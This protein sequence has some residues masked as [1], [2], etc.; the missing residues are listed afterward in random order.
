MRP[1]EHAPGDEDKAVGT[2][3]IELDIELRYHKGIV[4]IEARK[5][6]PTLALM[7]T[8]I[9]RAL[10]LEGIKLAFPKIAHIATPTIHDDPREPKGDVAR[11]RLRPPDGIHRHLRG[12]ANRMKEREILRA[13]A[14]TAHRITTRVIY[15][16]VAV[17]N[18]NDKRNDVRDRNGH[19][20]SITYFAPWNDGHDPRAPRG[21]T[22][23]L[24]DE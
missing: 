6:A 8:A 20:R 4:A 24:S 19:T 1:R 23:S 9:A 22:N 17:T 11:R 5:H 7:L 12:A 14:T 2:V 3:R 18:E 21:A 10:G 15:A 16:R 13:L